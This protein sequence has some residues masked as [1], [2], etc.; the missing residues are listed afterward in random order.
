M[1]SQARNSFALDGLDGTWNFRICIPE[2]FRARPEKIHARFFK[3]GG[4]DRT[5]FILRQ[6]NFVSRSERLAALAVRHPVPTVFENREFI[7]AGGLMGCGGR[8]AN[9]R[10]SSKMNLQ[11]NS[12]PRSKNRQIRLLERVR[13]FSPFN[14]LVNSSRTTRYAGSYSLATRGYADANGINVRRSVRRGEG[15]G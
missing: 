12:S 1:W 4:R 13:S 3:G 11:A 7:A 10:E 5:R 14:G 2:S 8:L 6:S 9:S 15:P